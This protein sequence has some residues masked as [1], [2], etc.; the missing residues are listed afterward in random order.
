MMGFV[1]SPLSLKLRA[2]C[3]RCASAKLRCEK[4]HPVC[5]RCEHLG[6]DCVYGPSRRKGKPSSKTFKSPERSMPLDC[7]TPEAQA[8][9]LQSSL[10]D[11]PGL[12]DAEMDFASMPWT[13]TAQRPE[14]SDGSASDI[15]TIWSHSLDVS[16]QSRQNSSS[17]GGVMMEA[18]PLRHF[19]KAREASSM[20][21]TSH[22]PVSISASPTLSIKPNGCCT[23]EAIKTLSN[24][25][26]LVCQCH[27]S[28]FDCSSACTSTKA[29]ITKSVSS[30][31][32]LLTARDAVQTLSRLAECSCNSCS[33]DSNIRFLLT[34]IALKTFD[35]YK[36]VYKSNISS[37]DRGIS[38]SIHT[39]FSVSQQAD[40]PGSSAFEIPTPPATSIESAL[41]ARPMT[42]GSFHLPQ[43]TDLRM[44]AQLL[45]CELQP[46]AQVCNTLY[47]RSRR[48]ADVRGEEVVWEAVGSYLQCG[49]RDLTRCLEGICGR[50]E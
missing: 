14:S 31:Q 30:D 26:Q 35:C 18:E 25:Y 12:L 23:S 5:R 8:Q 24:V 4:Q 34:N 17:I 27:H 1:S 15:S 29:P 9:H 28:G 50:Q 38:S 6:L 10:W 42:I 33:D 47:G 36:D 40:I 41:K 2:T 21:M 19:S 32:V 48:I 11:L 49:V 46:L 22:V 39:Q 44:K 3:D 16:G 45:L 37:V 43:A 20:K 7:A 13:E